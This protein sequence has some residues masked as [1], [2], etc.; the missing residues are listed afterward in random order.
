MKVVDLGHGG[1]AI[2]PESPADSV[3]TIT[4]TQLERSNVS[5]EAMDIYRN[6]IE[7]TSALDKAN[8]S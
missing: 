6:Y 3:R 8:K 4:R 2:E 7:R 1:L 5:N